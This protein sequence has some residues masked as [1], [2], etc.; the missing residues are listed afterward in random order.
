MATRQRTQIPTNTSVALVSAWTGLQIT[1]DGEPL[2][3]SQYTDKSVQVS[4]TFGGASVVIEG[5]NAPGLPWATLTDPQG[6]DLTITTAKIEM[7]AEATL[8]IRP[9]IVGGDGTTNLAVHLLGVTQ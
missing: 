5:R 2:V 6:N 4:G 7:V 9:R 3:F 1:D 8:E